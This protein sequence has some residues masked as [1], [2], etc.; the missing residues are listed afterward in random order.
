M[1]LVLNDCCGMFCAAFTY[2]TVV[3][4]YIGFIR[5]GI[6]EGLV[7]GNLI[8]LLHYLVFQY[9][10]FMIFWSHFKC[11]TTQPGLLPQGVMSLNYEKLPKG[12][13]NVIDQTGSRM[14]KLE[15]YIL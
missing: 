12:I 13:T 14:K 1:W 2:F 8:S 6:W 3:F 4:V 7:E 15:T 11:M 5:I 9:N 10:C